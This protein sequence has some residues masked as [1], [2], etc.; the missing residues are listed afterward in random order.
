MVSGG[1]V[2]EDI[3]TSHVRTY[4]IYRGMSPTTSNRLEVLNN[5]HGFS[6]DTHTPH[7]IILTYINYN[8][9][10]RYSACLRHAT[11]K[12]AQCRYRLHFPRTAP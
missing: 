8:N 11:L 2:P 4:Q 3:D 6:R 9:S 7:A 10:T 1:G 5:L 12:S